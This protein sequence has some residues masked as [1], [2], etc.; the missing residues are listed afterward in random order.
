MENSQQERERKT[1]IFCCWHFWNDV[2]KEFKMC[3]DKHKKKIQNQIESNRNNRENSE[4]QYEFSMEKTLYFIWHTLTSAKQTKYL[5]KKLVTEKNDVQLIYVYGDDNIGGLTK[6]VKKTMFVVKKI[7]RLTD[8]YEF[9]Y[10]SKEFLFPPLKKN[11]NLSDWN[12]W[13]EWKNID[14]Y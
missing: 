3:N 2:C 9:S 8:L 4:F 7:E 10:Y 5:V 14:Q 11:W 6:S 1:I 12:I 13:I